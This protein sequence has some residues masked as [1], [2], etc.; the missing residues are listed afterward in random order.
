MGGGSYNH[1]SSSTSPAAPSTA[2]A[3]TAP[4]PPRPCFEAS[5]SISSSGTFVRWDLRERGLLLEDL[6]ASSLA[7]FL[8]E[9]KVHG[10][11]LTRATDYGVW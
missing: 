8:E 11:A 7:D 4:P 10:G 9:A 6:V 5:G 1:R 2:T 3:S